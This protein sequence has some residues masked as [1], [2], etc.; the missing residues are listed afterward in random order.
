MLLDFLV[1]PAKRKTTR[2]LASS[3]GHLGAGGLFFLSI[4]DSSPIPTFA[5]PDILTAV[6][7]AAHKGPWYE[8]AAVATA[9]SV[10]GAYL[11]FRLARGAG[12][13][14]LDKKFKKGRVSAILKLFHRWGAG[15]LVASAAIPFPSPTSMLFAAAGVSKYRTSKFLALVTAARAFRYTAVALIADHYGRHFTRALRHPSQY[16]GWLLLFSVITFALITGGLV[17][18]RRLATAAD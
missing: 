5:G 8:Y 2:T 16:W 1:Q 18:N 17:I 15:A 11:T 3:I 7:S 4:L 10:I 14:Y 6:L 12:Q 9:G 13:A